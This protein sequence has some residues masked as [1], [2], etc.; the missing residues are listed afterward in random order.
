M[1]FVIAIY[2]MYIFYFNC[3]ERLVDINQ[4]LIKTDIHSL[5]LYLLRLSLSNVL[6]C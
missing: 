5:F 2:F 6:K 4:I 1:K 3:F